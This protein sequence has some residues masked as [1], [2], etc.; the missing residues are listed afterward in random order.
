MTRRIATKKDN[1]VGGKH[2]QGKEYISARI[3]KASRARRG[4][5]VECK[6]PSSLAGD[7]DMAE[8]NDKAKEE[9]EPGR[10]INVEARDPMQVVAVKEVKDGDGKEEE[11]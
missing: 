10:K 8:E 7:K 9:T 6:E 11:A 3:C 2:H 1:K 5:T 4:A